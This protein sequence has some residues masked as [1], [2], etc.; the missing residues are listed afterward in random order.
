MPKS[1]V[2]GHGFKPGINFVF[3]AEGRAPFDYV[4]LKN[5]FMKLMKNIGSEATKNVAVRELSPEGVIHRS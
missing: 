5:T 2:I 3:R 1:L 4:I